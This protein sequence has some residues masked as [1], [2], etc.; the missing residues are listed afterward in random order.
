MLYDLY[1]DPDQKNNLIDM[2]GMESISRELRE[3]LTQWMKETDDPL[4]DGSVAPPRGA[5]LTHPD[6][7]LAPKPPILAEK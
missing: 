6:A 1:F 4:C 2:Q 5:N 7:F 3:S